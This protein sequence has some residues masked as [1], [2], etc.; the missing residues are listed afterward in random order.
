MELENELVAKMKKDQ[1]L[2]GISISQGDITKSKGKP[3]Y[4]IVIASDVIEHIEDDEKL[5]EIMDIC[6][7]GR[8]LII[9][10]LLICICMVNAIKPGDIFEDMVKVT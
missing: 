5:Y 10:V 2:K 9:T 3:E 8:T 1:Q 7:S 6:R 4:D